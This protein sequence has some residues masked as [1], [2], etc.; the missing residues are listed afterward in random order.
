MN[1]MKRQTLIIVLSEVVLI[2]FYIFA[3]SNTTFR[4]SFTKSPVILWLVILQLLLV[5]SPIFIERS[6]ARNKSIPIL[7]INFLCVLS[8]AGVAYFLVH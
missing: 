2:A 7:I 8:G 3:F 6:S 5:A 4:G 1:S